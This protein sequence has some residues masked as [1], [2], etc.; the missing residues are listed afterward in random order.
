MH[1]EPGTELGA[2]RV[3]E[4]VGQGSFGEVYR[5][6]D[7]RSDEPVA[8]KLLRETG[9]A[10]AEL[11]EE[12]A[13]LAHLNIVQTL[14]VLQH[15]GHL[16]LVQE[17]ADGGTLEDRLTADGAL[18]PQETALLGFE[19]ASALA[20][21]HARGIVHRDVK[22][23]NVLIVHGSYKLGDFG[24]GTAV[25]LTTGLTRPGQIAGTPLYMSPEQAGGQRLSPASDIFNLG[26]VLYRALHGRLP[27]E[28]GISLFELL[29]RRHRGRIEVP[30]SPLR[31]VIERCLA[32]VP[33]DRPR[34]VELIRELAGASR[35]R[36][37]EAPLPAAAGGA[38]RLQKADV[39]DP[40]DIWAAS[41][42]IR[43]RPRVAG[44]VVLGLVAAVLLVAFFEQIVR[45][46]PGWGWLVRL[47]L[48]VAL[49][50]TGFRLSRLVRA[51]LASRVPEIERRA[52]EVLFATES[53]TDLTQS[54]MIEVD[55]V[56]RQLRTI[57]GRIL[58]MTLR[59]M[60]DEYGT[61]R[62]SSDR[63]TALAHVVTIM[64]KLSTHLSP[65][66]VRH[67]DTIATSVAVV[68]C[69]SGV[70]SVVSGFLS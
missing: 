20:H 5:A 70:A 27:D 63:I 49:A 61:A 52:A 23:S 7:L 39:P 45:P 69:L 26:L 40:E 18:S 11:A 59:A 32:T 15:D 53:R 50:S 12:L 16:C 57:D 21:A 19:L 37:P 4:L 66:H 31:T 67:K 25:E 1:L 33:E 9:A 46:L 43:R 10:E 30:P 58:G 24:M 14:D 48:A 65:W 36:P 17:W 42:P 3:G 62:Q 44:A 13:R 41:D 64:E 8:I 28:V 2:Y 47:A 6:R 29:D 60:V 68:G 51:R 22:P 38:P 34:A 56:V 35:P 54:L 55:E